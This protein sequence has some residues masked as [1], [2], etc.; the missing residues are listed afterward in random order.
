[1]I[2]QAFLPL[3]GFAARQP[4]NRRNLF[5]HDGWSIKRQPD[6][7]VREAGVIKLRD[8]KCGDGDNSVLPLKDTVIW[9]VAGSRGL[10]RGLSASALVWS[11]MQPRPSAKQS[12]PRKRRLPIT[13]FKLWNGLLRLQS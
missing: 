2:W 1:M 13:S 8:G 10:S 4:G 12:R 9:R 3:L 5:T 7:R 11:R 6:D